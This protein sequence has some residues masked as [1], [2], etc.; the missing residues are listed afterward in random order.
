MT[1]VVG[2]VGGMGPLATVKLF[3]N[4]VLLTDAKKDQEHLHI[5]I[6]NN[7]LIP[8]RTDYILNKNA[9]DPRGKLIE[10]AQRLEKAGA[11]FLIMP[12]NTAHNFYEDIVS[13]IGIPFLNMIEETAKHIKKNHP[14]KSKI[15]LLATDGT[16]K[17]GVY[18]NIFNKYS[19]EIA[20][21]ASEKQKHVYELI[22][23]IKKDV[24]QDSLQGFYQAMNEIKS[25]DTDLFI[26]G[27]T[28]ISV[29]LE[30]YNLQGNF[31]DPLKI[32]AI[33]AIEFAGGQAK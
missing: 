27:C 23:N 12:C 29:A 8:D 17:A 6:D 15:G 11:D 25:Q 28:E 10:S 22:Y 16:I 21:P 18:D 4:I 31:I 5:L 2:I 20:V 3:E 26:A 9:E 33:S 13:S 30:L 24:K 14:D 7:T 19:L 32:V 1:K